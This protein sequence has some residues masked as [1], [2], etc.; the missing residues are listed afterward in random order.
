MFVVSKDEIFN[1][2]KSWRYFQPELQ[3]HFSQQPG[4]CMMKAYKAMS[5]C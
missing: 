5:A 2:K 1:V 4:S 3:L